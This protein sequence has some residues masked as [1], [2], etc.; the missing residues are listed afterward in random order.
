MKDIKYEEL[1]T[2]Q[3]LKSPLF[4]NSETSLLYA[5][6]SRTADIFKANFRNMFAN[7]VHCP[8]DC[9]EE[10]EAK[11]DDTQKHLLLCSKLKCEIQTHDLASGQ[12]LYEDI[13][14]E[15]NKQKE[16]VVLFDRLIEARLRIL[17]ERENQP[18]GDDLDP[19]IGSCPRCVDSVFTL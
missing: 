1:K 7:V 9:Q 3:Y 10:G 16:A 14:G 2:Q 5:L 15:V 18:P 11:E 8:L 19:S 6:R 13:F 4:S 12:V 17:K